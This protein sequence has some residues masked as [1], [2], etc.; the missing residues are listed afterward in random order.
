VGVAAAA[1]IV[2]LNLHY[3]A[4]LRHAASDQATALPRWN[5]GTDADAL[6]TVLRTPPPWQHRQPLPDVL[7][8][9]Q[10]GGVSN[11]TLRRLL[12]VANAPS[13]LRV[14]KAAR[15]DAHRRG[16][17]VSPLLFGG[18]IEHMGRVIDGNHG[19]PHVGP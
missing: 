5:L 8:H 7:A 4:A 6:A 10:G 13:T 3:H 9:G 12:K 14:S 11:A 15:V 16:A 17:E 18:F 19:E 2:V 1:A